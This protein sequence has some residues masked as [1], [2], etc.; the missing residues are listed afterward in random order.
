MLR[1]LPALVLAALIASTASAQSTTYDFDPDSSKIWIEGTSNNT[2]HWT[3]YATEFSGSIT[4]GAASEN[5]HAAVEA[6]TL[7]VPTKMIKS[8]KSGIMDRVMYDALDIKTHPE[9]TFALTSVSDLEVTSASTATLVAH[10]DL[11]LGGQTNAV[12]IPI[13]ATLREDGMA[14]FTGSHVITLKD[15]GL[16][17][18]TAM[19]GSLRTGADVTVTAVFHAGPLQ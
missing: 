8:N 18:P 14:V 3:V 13:E 19:F 1:L 16:S 12:A 15:Y 2:P 17:P 10:G 11:T 7:T 4:L 5:S 9:V 6:V